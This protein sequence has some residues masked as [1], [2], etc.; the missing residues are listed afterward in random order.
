MEKLGQH[1]SKD[2]A[3]VAVAGGGAFVINHYAGQIEYSAF[4]FLQKN[5][6]A[7][8]PL[9][10]LALSS[11]Q[12]PLA[13]VLYAEDFYDSLPSKQRLSSNR[14]DFSLLNIFASSGRSGRSVR[15]SRRKDKHRAK[16]EPFLDV[17]TPPPKSGR[18][19][20]AGSGLG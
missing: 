5:R 9:V 8:P 14:G 19:A 15:K 10:T 17:R 18:N 1:L 2:E 3:Y 6:D 4:E 16:S 7:L 11:S 12:H 20:S 13:S